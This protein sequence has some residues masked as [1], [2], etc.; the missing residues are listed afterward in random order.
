[1]VH[2]IVL[3]HH[4]FLPHLLQLLLLFLE[5]VMVD[6]LSYNPITSF[7]HYFPYPHPHP[8]SNVHPFSPHVLKNHHPPTQTGALPLYVYVSFSLSITLSVC[9][10]LDSFFSPLV[11]FGTIS[12]IYKTH[13]HIVAFANFFFGYSPFFW[14]VGRFHD[15]VTQR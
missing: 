10:S 15:L 12:K 2:Q 1:M 14:I 3:Y 4:R 8:D 11:C 7:A 6:H 9:L 13:S 5:L